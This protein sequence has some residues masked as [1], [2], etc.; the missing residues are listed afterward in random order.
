MGYTTSFSGDFKISPPLS[1]EQAAYINKFSETR[2]MCRNEDKTSQIPDPIR[3]VVGLPV[4]KD[5]GYF[6]GAPDSEPFGQAKTDDVVN[7]NK[8]PSEQPSL[9]CQW[10]VEDSSEAK[11]DSLGWDGGEKFYCYVEWLEY[12]INHFFKPWGRRLDGTVHWY[13]EDSADMGVIEINNNDIKVGHAVISYE[14]T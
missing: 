10:V 4:G 1:P 6:V 13:G 3:E 14:Y 8:P 7:Y 12:M 9:W 11:F 5:G 2:R